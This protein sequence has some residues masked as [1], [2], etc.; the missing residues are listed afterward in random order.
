L[1][2]KGAAKVL[3]PPELP[4]LRA[5][6]PPAPPLPPP[7]A[8]PHGVFIRAEKL[9]EALSP[10]PVFNPA[11]AE[12]RA[13][14]GKYHQDASA[15]ETIARIAG[16]NPPTSYTKSGKT[17]FRHPSNGMQVVYDNSGK[18]FRVENTLVKGALRY[19]DQFGKIIP[20]NV[21]L[22][23]VKGI[24]QTGVPDDIRAALTHFN[25]MD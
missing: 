24:G 1:F 13:K 21:A 18:Y 17:I 14:F 2:G 15:K 25:D 22:I 4:L 6:P 20:N 12:R 9:E 23:K 19:T 3:P 7:P 11:G 10:V 8:P 16:D 5:P